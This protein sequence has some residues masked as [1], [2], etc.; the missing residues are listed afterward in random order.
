METQT[1]PFLAEIEHEAISTGHLLERVPAS[2]MAWRPHPK[3]MSLGQLALHVATIPANIA[4]LLEGSGVEAANLAVHPEAASDREIREAW[5][6]TL[7]TVREKLKSS[8]E[9]EHSWSITTEGKPLLTLPHSAVRRM[10]MLNHWYHHR[11]QLT[12][13]LR[14]L[15]VPIPSIYG[16]SADEDPFA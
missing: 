13:Y 7:G 14:L 2:R 15:D 12:V 11:G 5:Q 9:V 16:P 1:N 6:N 10:L 3:S 4:T 8:T